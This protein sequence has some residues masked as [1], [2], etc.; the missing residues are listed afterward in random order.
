MKKPTA[1]VFLLSLAI[2]VS[3]CSK[4]KTTS[5][6]SAV[7]EHLAWIPQSANAVAYLDAQSLRQSELGKAFEKD[8]SEGMAEMRKDRHF[9]RMLEAAGFDFEKDFHS[10]LAGFHGGVHDSTSAFALVATGNFDEQKIITTINAERDSLEEHYGEHEKPELITETYNGKTIYVVKER[11]E[12]AFYFPDAHTIAA[13]SKGWVQ[14]IIDGNTVDRSI[15]QNAAVVELMNK[16][17]F[18]DQCWL[19]ANTVEVMERMAEEMGESRNFK[20]TRAVKAVQNVVFSAQV[21]ERAELDGE[22]VCD[23]EENS[24]LLADAAK[25]ALA[26]AKLAVSDDR[27]AVD[28]LNRIEIDMKGKSVEF[29]ANLDKAF[30][31]KLRERAGKHRKAIA[32]F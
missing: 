14:Q 22:A 32:M 17:R 5:L 27:E 13:G 7:D 19:V 2:F 1:Y 23:N 16:L 15:K 28:M 24:R 12:K 8:F 21:G 26:T 3:S 4:T 20:G 18:K 6:P 31:D 30:F 11:G 25:G 29:A 9:R 10:V